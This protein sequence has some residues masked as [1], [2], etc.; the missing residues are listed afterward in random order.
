MKLWPQIP[1][2][3]ALFFAPL[4]IAQE[5]PEDSSAQ[6]SYAPSD[7]SRFAPRSALDMVRQLPGFSVDND[8][9]GS[10]GFGQASGNVLINGQRVSGKSNGVRDALS[11]IP[12]ENVER[13]DIVDGAS[14]DIPGL[15]GQ[16]ANVIS[17]ATE[18]I[19]GNWNWEGR[20]REVVRPYF[21]EGEISATG[22]S[23]NLEWT[24]GFEG[25]EGR[26]GAKGFENV[27]DA[28]GTLTERRVEK[29]NFIGKG[30][31]LSGSLAWTP[32]S[33]AIANFN[34]S[35][36][37]WQPDIKEVSIRTPQ[38]GGPQ[39]DRVFDRSEDE[40]NT[41]IGGDYEFA[42]GPGRLKT[43]GLYRFE[44]SPFR[45]RVFAAAIDASSSEETVFNQVIDESETILRSEYGWSKTEGRD[46]QIA[47]EIA[48]NTLESDA[49]FFEAFDFAPLGPDEITDPTAKVEELRGEVSAT[50]GRKLSEKLTLQTSLGVE[51]SEISQSGGELPEG[52]EVSQTFTIPKGFVSASYTVRDGYVLSGRIERVVGQL[53]FFDFIS[54][55]NI[56]DDIGRNANPDLSPQQSWR[57]EVEA[58]RNFGD[59]GAG[60]VKIFGEDIE[61]VVDRIPLPG[62]GDGVGNID[63]ASLIGIEFSGTLKLDPIGWNGV[64]IEATGDYHQ[65]SLTDPLTGEDRRPNNGHI[66][67]YEIEF[68]HDIPN[69]DWAWGIY[70]EQHIDDTSFFL[71]QTEKETF[72]SAFSNVFIEHKDIFGMTGFF[73]VDNLLNRGDTSRRDFFDPD[74][75]GVLSGQE[76]RRRKFGD[77]VTFGLS[78][79]F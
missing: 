9:D 27:L 61:D 25:N 33:G 1:A 76:I 12:A 37:S 19:S 75:T 32:D 26:G 46:W 14:L 22:K 66:Y 64:Q 23:G 10:R 47:G 30:G 67:Q 38:D 41:E 68:R 17:T 20:V 36:T 2:G 31:T 59:W 49:D 35:Y 54:S 34:A 55:S 56:N 63:S 8:D 6:R 50:Y 65:S 7:F 62:G 13:I 4:A 71:D 70:L 42:L 24:L 74:R 78:G 72:S 48:L 45:N 60:S 58:E 16:V 18:G 44:H 52:L 5:T 69:T 11:R 28:S 43:I 51:V 57:L 79:S 21:G 73:R 77:M 29:F 39:I 40:W 3:L 53:N 15:S